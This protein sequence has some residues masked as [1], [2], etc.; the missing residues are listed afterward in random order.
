MRRIPAEKAELTR[1]IL[2]FT[3]ITFVGI[4]WMLFE[5]ITPPH[6]FVSWLGKLVR[7]VFL[8]GILIGVL[9]WI[10]PVIFRVNYYSGSDYEIL[11]TSILAMGIGFILS[12][13]LNVYSYFFIK[14]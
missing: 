3:A 4:V 13:V 11:L 12:L 14:V 9:T 10:L 2:W 7:G 5:G 1:L 6:N 8:W